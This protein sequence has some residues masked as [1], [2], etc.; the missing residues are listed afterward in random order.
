MASIRNLDRQSARTY[1]R[2][3]A[4]ARIGLGVSAVLA[5]TL[6]ARPW[7]GDD[8]DRPA[9]KV[10]ARALGGRDIALGLGAVLA[11]SHD[12]PVRGWIEGAALADA[13]DLAATLLSFRSLPRAGRLGIV[14]VTV[15]AVVAARVLAPLVD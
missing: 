3:L 10:L 13:G 2:W 9:V 6:P 12:G 4:Y 15:G 7:V 11:L 5:P 1:T 14:G 8:A